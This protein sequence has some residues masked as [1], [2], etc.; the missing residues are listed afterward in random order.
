MSRPRKRRSPARPQIR[1]HLTLPESPELE[2]SVL[3]GLQHAADVGA[4]LARLEAN[5]FASQG[6]RTI[7]RAIRDLAAQGRRA[8]LP[9]LID[10]LEQAGDLADIGGR[11]YVARLD[12][13]LNPSNL[14]G[15]IDRLKEIRSLR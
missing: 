5:D 9:Q 1:G 13:D 3:G 6:H 15:Y 7:L 14:D 11:A 12:L 8:D 10:T 4:A 2:R